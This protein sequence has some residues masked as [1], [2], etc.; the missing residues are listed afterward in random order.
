MAGLFGSMAP[1]ALTGWPG[2]GSVGR[3]LLEANPEAAYARLM[4]QMGLDFGPDA[5]TG[6]GTYARGQSGEARNRYLAELSTHQNPDQFNYV[7]FLDQFGGQLHPSFRM[8]SAQQQGQ[9]YPGGVQRLR[10]VGF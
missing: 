3:D 8:Q 1:G 10:Y 9:R 7:D 6:F 4:G 2:V 5:N